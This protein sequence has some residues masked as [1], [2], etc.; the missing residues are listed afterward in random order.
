MY[1]V[2]VAKHDETVAIDAA[3]RESS[4]QTSPKCESFSL[5]NVQLFTVEA[6]NSVL[7]LECISVLSDNLYQYFSA[8]I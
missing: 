3:D 4:G 6:F 8:F 2:I 7:G 5:S 1:Y